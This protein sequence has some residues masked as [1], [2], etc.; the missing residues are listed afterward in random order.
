[1]NELESL[2]NGGDAAAVEGPFVLVFLVAGVLVTGV[3]S[4]RG[5]ENPKLAR[6]K[7]S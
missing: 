5:R 6:S 2:V 3:F 1:M 4:L 7:L